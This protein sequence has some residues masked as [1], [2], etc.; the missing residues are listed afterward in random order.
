M[1]SKTHI[2]TL[3]TLAVAVAAIVTMSLP[4]PAQAPPAQPATS[5]EKFTAVGVNMKPGGGENITIR[6][7]RWSTDEDRA[8]LIAALTEKGDK[9]LEGFL[10][11]AMTVG[12][13]WTSESL[14]YSLR[15]AHHM[16]I[17][18]GG[19]RIILATDRRLGV[20]TRGNVWKAISPQDAPDYPFTV[21]E[22]RMPPRGVGEGK[23][24][25]STKIAIEQDAKTIALENYKSAPILLKDVK[26]EAAAP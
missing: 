17:P 1:V 22:F 3:C 9:E 24:S 23:M 5:A 13:I 16:P 4:T 26:H 21:I 11:S 2:G 10:N 8:R 7:S 20:W 18:G 12:Y 19:E 6:I 15:F 25:I 14:G